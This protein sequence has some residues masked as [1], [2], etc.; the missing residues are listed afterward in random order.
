MANI[1]GMDEAGM[2]AVGKGVDGLVWVVGAAPWGSDVPGM[3]TM[4][5]V[6][7]MSDPEGKAYRPLPYALG[8]CGVFF[9]GEAMQWAAENG[10]ITGENIAKGMYA[11]KDW[12]PYGLD[13]ICG[14]RNWTAEDPRGINK[15]HGRA[16]GRE[17]VCQ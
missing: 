10:G 9:M 2:K 1:W 13:G 6:S 7:K 4:L 3:K 16:A 12:V 8:A 14:P 5:E 17:R 11:K 15:E